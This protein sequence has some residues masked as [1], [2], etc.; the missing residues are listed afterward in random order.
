M[1]VTGLVPARF[2]TMVAHI[3]ILI[4][5]LWSRDSNVK[6]C[7][8]STYTQSQYSEKDLQLIIGLSVGLGLFLFELI[9]FFGGITMFAPFQSLLSISAHCGACVALAYFV[10]H[11]W[12]CERYWYI[13]GICSAFPALTEIVTIIM[14]VCCGRA[15]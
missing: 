3:V 2:L 4:F 8:P 15:I 12:P 9:G 13:F 5:I 7:L 14:V 10:W 1:K 6:Q 11:G